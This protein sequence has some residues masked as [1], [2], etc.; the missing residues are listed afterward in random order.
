MS[1]T[2]VADSATTIAAT[3][4]KHCPICRHKGFPPGGICIRK[5]GPSIY[6]SP[7][8]ISGISSTPKKYLKF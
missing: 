2:D 3:Q 8:K 1:F 6:R 4:I 7:Q 5:L